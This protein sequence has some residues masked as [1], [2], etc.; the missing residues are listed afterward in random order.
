M[1]WQARRRAQLVGV[2]RRDA[3]VGL[4]VDVAE[5]FGTCA[6]DVL[7]W[8]PSGAALRARHAA[9]LLLVDAGWPVSAAYRVCGYSPGGHP[10]RRLRSAQRLM[11]TDDRFARLV[12]DLACETPPVHDHPIA[13]EALGLLWR[14]PA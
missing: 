12:L 6:A 1:S 2:P 11:R 4:L 5:A 7:G 10:G 3:A 13:A 8:Y 9:M 14:K